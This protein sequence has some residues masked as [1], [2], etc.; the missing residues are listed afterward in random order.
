MGGA[1]LALRLGVCRCDRAFDYLC[2]LSSAGKFSASIYGLSLWRRARRQLPANKLDIYFRQHVLQLSERLFGDAFCRG[3][4]RVGW[5]EIVLD[6]ICGDLYLLDLYNLGGTGRNIFIYRS[7]GLAFTEIQKSICGA[8]GSRR[9]R[10]YRDFIFGFKFHCVAKLSRGALRVEIARRG[11]GIASFV[12]AAGLG[13]RSENFF[14]RSFDRKRGGTG[15]QQCYLS[16]YRRD[17][18]PVD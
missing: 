17:L 11:Y 13:R 8:P 1:G 7:M 14:R 15:G 18:Q 10:R 4:I 2:F 5:K 16:K 12:A 6:I 3:K 9:R